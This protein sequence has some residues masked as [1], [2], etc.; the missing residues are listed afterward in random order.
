MTTKP[1]RL[2][3]AAVV[4]RIVSV[5]AFSLCI[6]VAAAAQDFEEGL[7]AKKRGDFAAALAAWRPLAERGHAGAQNGLGLLYDNGEGVPQ[8]HGRALA[9]Y[10]KSAAQGYAGAQYNLGLMYAN[11]LGVPQSYEK[12]RTW[13]QKAADQGHTEAKINLDVLHL[14]GHVSKTD[15]GKRV[16]A[17]QHAP[18]ARTASRQAMLAQAEEPPQGGADAGQSDTNLHAV[19]AE[20]EQAAEARAANDKPAA[21]ADALPIDPPTQLVPKTLGQRSGDK[22]APGKPMNDPAGGDFKVQLSSVKTELRAMKEAV[23]L[24]QAHQSLLGLLK[25]EPVR[26]DLGDRG[27][28]FRLRAGPVADWKAAKELCRAL[29]ARNQGCLVVR[30]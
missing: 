30:P 18:T 22:S 3:L 23:R 12:A 6:S 19:S 25:I 11:G 8:N 13:Y 20:S 28:F 2:G 4:K 21:G 24:K 5:L 7:A 10:R 26:V 1:A 15:K 9:W 17:A 27:V 14:M 29:A 16:A